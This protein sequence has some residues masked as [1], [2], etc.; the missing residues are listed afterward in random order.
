M[1]NELIKEAFASIKS[2]I[3][4]AILTILIITIG[5][6]ALVGIL[7]SIDSIK[8]SINSNFTSMGANTFTIRNRGLNIHI[9]KKGKKA[10]RFKP[11]SFKEALEF[12]KRFDFP[13]NV[14]LSAV[15]SRIA[16]LK[17]RSNKTNPNIDVIG[18]DENY[19]IN[20][21]YEIET[22]RNFSKS[23]LERGSNVIII[24]KEIL[25]TLFPE[26]KKP[27]GELI[28]VGS[29]KY[30]VIGI[31]KSKGSSFGFGGDKI[32]I[33]PLLN[34]KRNFSTQKTSYTISVLAMSPY[35]M[36]IAINEAKGLFHIIRK[37]KIS[38]EDSFEIIRSD[39][40][41][42]ML[43]ENIKY[44]TIAATLIGII[45]L[46]GAAIGLMNIMLVSVTERTREIGTRKAMGA[47][48][49]LI[50][51]QFLTEAILICQLGGI[52]G[53]IIGI[54]LGNVVSFIIGSN[55]I[56]PWFWIIMAVVL[57]FIVG[58]LSGIY[59]AKKAAKLNPIDALRYE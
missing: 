12:K 59:P 36:E 35:D 15:A 58:V 26:K 41:A 38:S 24:G 8:N 33:I 25:N 37:D 39:S 10:K 29:I 23:E 48:P 13:A 4:R 55:F 40:L 21:G 9:G 11:I 31:L 42:N 49:K 56:V 14:S 17:Y 7:T 28:S 45:T 44:V 46:L 54:L 32:A 19:L 16:V 2:Q 52:F 50:R 20:S 3:L 1:L 57:C 18:G 5:I 43:I 22:G 6:T 53:I 34:M 47:T 27:L 51:W 30:K